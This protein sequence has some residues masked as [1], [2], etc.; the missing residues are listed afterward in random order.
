[1]YCPPNV[2]LISM[3]YKGQ[4]VSLLKEMIAVYFMNHT[5]HILYIHSVD[6]MDSLSVNEGGKSCSTE[7]RSLPSKNIIQPRT[8]LG[9]R[10]PSVCNLFISLLHL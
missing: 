7:R 6:A 3:E 1:M 9:M 2:L 5:K 8:A 10:V 4:T